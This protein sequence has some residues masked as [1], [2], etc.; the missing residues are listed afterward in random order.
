[1]D[2][3][4]H[5]S[6]NRKKYSVGSRIRTAQTEFLQVELC[7]LYTNFGMSSTSSYR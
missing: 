3:D 1:M 4:F 7:G 2:L 6:G 5:F